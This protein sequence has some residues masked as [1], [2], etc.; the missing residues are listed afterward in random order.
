MAN[1]QKVCHIRGEK[2]ILLDFIGVLQILQLLSMENDHKRICKLHRDYSI[3]Q[4]DLPVH[5]LSL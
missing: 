1:K 3:M 4:T 2:Q 5:S